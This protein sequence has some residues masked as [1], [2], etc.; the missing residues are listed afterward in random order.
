[1]QS[2]NTAGM[3][4]LDDGLMSLMKSNIISRQQAVKYAAEPERF[5]PKLGA[6]KK[7]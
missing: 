7:A 4:T 2:S 1:M 3:Q 5:M 6:K